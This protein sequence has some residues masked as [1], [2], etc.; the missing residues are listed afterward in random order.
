VIHPLAEQALQRGI[1]G[2]VFDAQPVIRCVVD[3]L[4]D[5]IG[6]IKTLIAVISAEPDGAGAVSLTPSG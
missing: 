6:N 2:P 1:K 3:A 5:P 4:R